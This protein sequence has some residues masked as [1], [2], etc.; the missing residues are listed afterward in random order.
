[1]NM[2]PLAALVASL[3]MYDSPSRNCAVLAGL[4]LLARHFH[5]YAWN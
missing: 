3:A 2:L 5:L 1:M 4:G